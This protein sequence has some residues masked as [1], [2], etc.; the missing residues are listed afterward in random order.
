MQK[1]KRKPLLQRLGSTLAN[2]LKPV[3]N[4]LTV[5]VKLPKH[6][7]TAALIG[8]CLLG[9]FL[10]SGCTPAKTIKPPLPPQADP[11]PLPR[12][13]GSTYRELILWSIDV[14]ESFLS[15]EADKA[16]IRRMYK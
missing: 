5:R 6:L 3:S 10:L 16:A 9:F 4:L 15:C 13:T 2:L 8:L 1:L 14:R 12:F 7:M 11:R